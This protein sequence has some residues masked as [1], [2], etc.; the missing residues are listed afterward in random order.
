[1][2]FCMYAVQQTQGWKFTSEMAW[3]VFL[4]HFPKGTSIANSK[5]VHGQLLKGH[6]GKDRAMEAME[7]SANSTPRT[8]RF[9]PLSSPR[10]IAEH[11]SR[12][13]C[14]PFTFLVHPTGK[15]KNKK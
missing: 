6:Q 13:T 14:P 11:S 5:K 15:V 2:I 3:A 1:M 4:F 8:T 7:A 12:S 9:V 10:T